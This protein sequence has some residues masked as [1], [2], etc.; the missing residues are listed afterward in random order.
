MPALAIQQHHRGMAVRVHVFIEGEHAGG[1]S[2]RFLDLPDR[3]K[4]CRQRAR[5]RRFKRYLWH[6]HILEHSAKEMMRPFEILAPV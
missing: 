2:F 5:V 4:R 6:C 3:A 1:H